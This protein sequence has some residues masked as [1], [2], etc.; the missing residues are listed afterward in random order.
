L[1]ADRGGRESGDGQTKNFKQ[2]SDL[3]LWRGKH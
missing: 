1:D 3:K 2:G